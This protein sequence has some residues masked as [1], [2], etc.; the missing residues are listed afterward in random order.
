V[1][2]PDAAAAAPQIP[3]VKVSMSDALEVLVDVG[4]MTVPYTVA[5]DGS[6]LIKALVDRMAAV[7]PTQGSRLLA[8]AFAHTEK[9]W[10]HSIGYRINGGAVKVLESRSEKDKD[11]DHSVGVAIVE[12]T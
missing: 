9:E 11:N 12:R 1:P 5:F 10:S 2:V 6:T 7:P 3:V 8:W 4:P